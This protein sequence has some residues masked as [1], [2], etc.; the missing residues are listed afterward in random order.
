[1]SPIHDQWELS[2]NPTR[3]ATVRHA[4]ELIAECAETDQRGADA[5]SDRQ[6]QGP[7][8]GISRSPNR[9]PTPTTEAYSP[10]PVLDEEKYQHVISVLQSL[11]LFIERNPS[12]FASLNEESIRDHFLLHLNGHYPGGATGETFNRSGKTDIL[13][14]VGDRNVFIAECKFWRGPKCFGDAI[15]QL[16]AYLSWR[17][18]KCALL[19]FNRTKDSTAVAEKMHDE[20]EARSECRRTLSHNL[21]GESRYIFVKDSDPGRD[22]II[23][24]SIFDVPT[25]E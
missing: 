11:S 23:S 8:V 22:I 24:T 15:D 18:C 17:D 4:L 13:L 20:M 6:D 3:L 25:D 10:E 5:G 9:R 21:D 16:L 7:A 14:R 12:S 19:V 2:T 1:M